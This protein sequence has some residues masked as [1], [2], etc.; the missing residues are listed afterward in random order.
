M[1][2]ETEIKAERERLYE[3]TALR[4]ELN[5]DEATILLEWGEKHVVRLAQAS[6]DGAA[7]EQQAR[8]LRQLLKNINRFVG[9]RQYNNR[10]EQLVYLEKVV[11]WLGK[12]GFKEHS[13]PD[14]IDKMPADSKDMAATLRALLDAIDPAAPAPSGSGPGMPPQG[15]LA[16]LKDALTAQNAELTGE[17]PRSEKQAAEDAI[18]EHMKKTSLEEAA[19]DRTDTP[20][21]DVKENS[22]L[23]ILR[24]TLGL[25][26]SEPAHLAKPPSEDGDSTQRTP[27]YSKHNDTINHPHMREEDQ[28]DGK[29]SD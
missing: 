27:S 5:D 2:T 9:Q 28:D 23:E 14:L 22:V 17:P 26:S 19:K 6:A 10:E 8:F 18:K 7:L 3:S 21:S 20:Q 15:Q 13:G 11:Q 24:K 1:P 16:I 25:T 29:T 4:D 12:L